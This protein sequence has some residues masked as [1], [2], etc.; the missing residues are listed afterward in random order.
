MQKEFEEASFALQPGE[1]SQV[2]E[3]ASGLHIIERYVLFNPCAPSPR[4]ASSSAS[5]QSKRSSRSIPTCLPP[6]CSANRI[7][8]CGQISLHR[9]AG[10]L[11][12]LT[13]SLL[14]SSNIAALAHYR[15]A[16]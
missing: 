16:E 5:R 8:A 1:V 15:T 7:P 11:V 9:C 12:V 6:I 4:V 10:F 2:I 3:T 14:G 13:L